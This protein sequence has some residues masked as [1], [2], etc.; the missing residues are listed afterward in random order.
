MAPEQQPCKVIIVGGSI[1]GLSLANML[2]R[3][4]ID[5]VVLE[6][7]KEI[8]PQVGASITIWPHFARILDQ[9]GCWSNH[10]HL[11]VPISVKG[12]DKLTS[13]WKGDSLR[14]LVDEYCNQ[15]F[16]RN[17][18]GESVFEFP[19]MGDILERRHGYPAIFIDRQMLVS[20]LY[21]NLRH[22]DKVLVQ[23]RLTQ[24]EQMDDGVRAITQDGST[25]IGDIIIG[26]DG[27][28]SCVREIMHIFGRSF[29]SP[30]YFGKDEYSSKRPVIYREISSGSMTN[31]AVY[32]QE[33][34]CTYKCIF[35]MSK[36]TKGIEKGT[37]HVVMGKNYSYGIG[38]GTGK[39]YWF[40]NV[41]NS[42]TTYG[43]GVPRYTV[44]DEQRLAEQHFKDRLNEYDT[45]EDVYRN[46][47]K[48]RLTPLHEYQWKRWY[49]GRIMTIGDASHKIHP[50]SGNGGA[51]AIE[52]AATLVNELHGKFILQ[53]KLGQA[54]QHL[55][56]EE[57]Q[58]IFAKTQRAQEDRSKQLL[59]QSTKIQQGDAM[60]SRFAPLA[61]KYILP[62]LTGEAFFSLCRSPK[63]SFALSISSEDP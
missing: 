55:S 40:L 41:K 33:V 3:V 12:I 25:Y 26:A 63:N 59:K 54:S 49:F 8:A 46:R 2:E 32:F 58:E 36:P 10:G 37:T 51:A 14:A 13:F 48:S 50:I 30:D 56:T 35:G 6:A 24:I 17:Q 22:K 16:Y 4:G 23:K 43:R 5:F 42:E 47:I 28:H 39:I 1:A 31:C 21:Q 57:F 52:D 61:V 34:P 44:E 20:A 19:G 15:A 9:I 53:R 62:H 29:S 38:S 45:F 7:Y 18:Q 60:E 11:H 27:M